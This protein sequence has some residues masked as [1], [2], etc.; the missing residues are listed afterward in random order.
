L[1]RDR[2][3]H[4]D[5]AGVIFTATG[6]IARHPFSHFVHSLPR[7]KL[8]KQHEGHDNENG[9]LPKP[10]VDGR[11]LISF[12]QCFGCKRHSKD[13]VPMPR[14]SPATCRGVQAIFR[15]MGHCRISKSGFWLRLQPQRLRRTG[16]HDT[17]AYSALADSSCAAL[18]SHSNRAGGLSGC[19]K[20]PQLIIILDGP[21]ASPHHF[22]AFTLAWHEEIIGNREDEQCQQKPVEYRF[23]FALENS[24]CV[25]FPFAFSP[26]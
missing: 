18:Q 26:V 7:H 13:C 12:G 6:W 14:D 8:E 15:P 9:A 17:Q 16:Q 22:F 2:A 25:H 20:N 10:S 23:P 5:G 19:S 21:W 24:V 1:R 4:I 11:D 3:L